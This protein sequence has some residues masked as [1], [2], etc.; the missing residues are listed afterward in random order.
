MAAD[1]R[2]GNN[3][4]IIN[5]LNMLDAEV[6]RV[7]LAHRAD[8]NARALYGHTALHGLAG[9][10]DCS[11]TA[12][13]ALIDSGAEVNMPTRA[14]TLKWRSI[15]GFARALKVRGL[16][17]AVFTRLAKEEGQTALHEAVDRSNVDAIQLLI[18]RRADPSLRNCMGQSPLDM[19][20]ENFAGEVPSVI[21]DALAG[22]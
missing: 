6:V 14:K 8:I 17:D 5:A 9:S 2:L 10:H 20:L 21:A 3:A 22:H 7:L 1:S 12:I 15:K 19:A 16:A 4:L 13:E 18:A 11:L